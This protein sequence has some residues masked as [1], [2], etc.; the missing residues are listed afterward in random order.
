MWVKIYSIKQV[1]KLKT[2]ELLLEY[3]LDIGDLAMAN[4]VPQEMETSP[5]N[6]K[7]YSIDI[8]FPDPHPTRNDPRF[9]IYIIKKISPDQSKAIRKISNDFLNG[10]WWKEI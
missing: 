5:Q 2:H 3:P 1:V 8:I 7:T 10:C 4:T 6:S 9:N